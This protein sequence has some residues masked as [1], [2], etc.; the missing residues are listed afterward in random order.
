MAVA[1]SFETNFPGSVRTARKRVK[2]SELKNYVAANTVALTPQY[3]EQR[4]E[5]AR[6]FVGSPDNFWEN[7][8][9][10]DEKSFQSC[11]DASVRVYPP[12]IISA[13]IDS[14][15]TFGLG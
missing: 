6:Q 13:A 7:I 15:L 8:I 12:E 11:S 2:D 9:F 10:S 5:F 3:K 1:A 4:L 14:P